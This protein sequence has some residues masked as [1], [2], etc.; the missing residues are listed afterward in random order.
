MD[1]PFIRPTRYNVSNNYWFLPTDL[2][3]T[4]QDKENNTKTLRNSP[5]LTYLDEISDKDKFKYILIIFILILFIYRLNLNWT[6]WIGLLVGL[7]IVYYFNENQA[8]QMN[9]SADQLW[10]ILKS[11]LL[12]NTKYLVT[13]P[14]MIRWV[15]DVGELKKFNVLEFNKMVTSMDRF[16]KLIYDVKLGVYRG[17]ENLDLIHDQKIACLNQFHSLI[18]NID[19]ADIRTKYN[20]YFNELGQLLNDR[21]HQLIKICRSYYLMKPI[22]ID[23][24]LAITGMD[25]PTANDTKYDAHYNFYH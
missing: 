3:K 21:H 4:E 7:I 16:L 23:S 9:T 20:H 8:Q 17:K 6:I 10:A 11:P 13:D 1:Y 24:R 15:S 2:F 14:P 25:E 19:D 12:K 18:Y 22:D 5:I